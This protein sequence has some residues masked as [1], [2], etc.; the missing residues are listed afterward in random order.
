[1]ARKGNNTN[2]NAIYIPKGKDGKI[3]IPECGF[4]NLRE[5]M[6]DEQLIYA[7]SIIN[8]TITFCNAKAGTGKTTVAVA[9]MKYLYDLGLINK[10]YYVFSTPNEK[11]LG[12]RPGDVKE[13][14][15]DYLLPLTDALQEIGEFPP[16]ALDE[17]EGWV[18]AC[19]HN[20]LRGSNLKG[21]GII[22]D[23]FQNYNKSEAKKTLTRIHDN[24]KVVVCGH[25]QQCDLPKKEQSGFVPMYK[26][27]KEL[28]GKRP[29]GFVELTIN[30]RGWL[31]Q[32]AD[33]LE[34]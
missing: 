26:L 2:T 15:S 19:S 33:L 29:I 4:Y 34:I 7:D 3:Q 18:V 8:N 23:E 20:F 24:C 21:V 1:M 13:K 10:L 32:H 17:K 28:D 30:F 31:S 11:A 5:K 27:F 14:E 6:T 25:D 9:C 16:K 12:Y 22:L